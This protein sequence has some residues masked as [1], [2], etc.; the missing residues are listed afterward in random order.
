MKLTILFISLFVQTGAG[1][2]LQSVSV[3]KNADPFPHNEL[4]FRKK[5]GHFK[6]NLFTQE[7]ENDNCNASEPRFYVRNARYMELGSAVDILV[8]SFY[9]PSSLVRPYLFLSELARLQGNFP[10]DDKVHAF[11][12]ACSLE[13]TSKEEKI[14]GFVDVDIR[15][16]TKI[17]DAP[18]P[19]LSDLAV[20]D[21]HRRK[22]VAKALIRRCEKQ[23]MDWGRDHL[24]LRVDKKNDAA[25]KMY[26]DLNYGKLDHPHFGVGRDTTI[27]LKR[28]F[29]H[30]TE[31]KGAEN[32]KPNVVGSEEIF[33]YVI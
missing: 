32:E 10:Y 29:N 6:L 16:G 15:P 17:R 27:L 3:A 22:G 12:V 4:I 19:Y 23:A 13:G 25:L 20:H 7:Q 2:F 33:I 1:A 28:E 24:H 9:K 31:D 14:I 11:F 5:R 30:D 8:E 26:S 21:E 18:R